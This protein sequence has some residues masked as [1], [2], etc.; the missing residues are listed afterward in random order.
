MRLLFI[1]TAWLMFV[2][3]VLASEPA[4]MGQQLERLTQE[5]VTEGYKFYPISA[6]FNGVSAFNG[7]YAPPWSPEL[8]KA[9]QDYFKRY[10]H[11]LSQLDQAQLSASEQITFDIFQY[12]LELGLERQQYPEELL[13]FNPVTGA[14]LYFATL[15]SGSSGQPFN[16]EQDYRDFM[17]R[18]VG[19]ARW[20]DSM[21]VRLEEAA[22]Q[23]KVLP[24]FTVRAVVKQLEQQLVE[25]V[26]DSPFY[27][28][29]TRL[30]EALSNE[31]SAA[32]RRDYIATI[33]EVILPTYQ[34]LYT[35][36][37]TDYAGKARTSIALEEQD[38]GWYAFYIKQ[39]T[40]LEL[41]PQA[42][43]N[44]G[45]HIVAQNKVA[46]KK[47]K[48][49][50]GFT[51]SLP[52][53][54]QHLRHHDAYYFASAEA[55]IQAY[56]QA[57]ATA[58]Q[59]LDKLFV[60]SHYQDYNVA[61]VPDFAAAQAPKATYRPP[62]PDGSRPATLYINTLDL[63]SQ[64]KY[65]VDSVVLHEAAPGHHLQNLAALQNT[66]LSNYRKSLNFSAYD[67]GWGLYAE[68]LGAQLGLYATP[69]QQLGRVL[70]DQQRAVRVV[71]DTGIHALGWT[72]TQA[73]DYMRENTA[74]S[75]TEIDAEIARYIASPGQALAYKMGE[76]EINALRESARAALGTA[77]S[78]KAFHQTVLATGSVPLPI[79]KQQVRTWVLE[80]LKKQGL[81][82]EVSFTDLAALSHQ[83]FAAI[84]AQ[85]AKVKADVEALF[86]PFE[87][88]ITVAVEFV[89]DNL[90]EVGGVTGVAMTPEQIDISIARQFQA[91][92]DKAIAEGLLAT[93]Y[94]E[95]HHLVRGW[96]VEQNEFLPSIPNAAV[97]EGLAVVFAEQMSGVRESWLDYPDHVAQWLDEILELPLRSDYQQW[98]MGTHPDGRKYVGY[99]VGKY[100]IESALKHSELS[101]N[102]LTFKP[103][104][105][106]IEF[107]QADGRVKDAIDKTVEAYG[108]EALL[109]LKSLTLLD[110]SQQFSRGQ[111]SNVWQGPAVTYLNEVDTTFTIDFE[112]QHKEFK[113]MTR[114]IVGSH[115][116]PQPSI[117]HHLFVDNQGYVVDHAQASYR[118]VQSLRFDTVGASYEAFSDLLIVRNMLTNPVKASWKDIAYIENQAHDVITFQPD[119]GAE[120]TVYLN[121]KTGFIRRLTRMQQDERYT[122]DFLEHTKQNG[123]VYAQ[124]LMVSHATAP[125]YVTQQRTVRY[126]SVTPESIKLP[127][128]VTL[129]PA[130]QFVDASSL[131]FRELAP[132]V[133]FVG[134]DWSYTLFIDDGDGFISAG[135]WQ[136]DAES[137]E[138]QK[139]YEL[140]VQSTGKEL[141][142]KQHIVTHHHH[143]HLHGVPDI[144]AQ[145]ATLIAPAKTVDAIYDYLANAS[146]SAP[147]I[148]PVAD[149]RLIGTRR[150]LL[151][152]VP[153][154]HASHNLAVYLPDAKLLFTEDVFGSSLQQGFHSPS[155]WPENDT[156]VRLE[157]LL[158]KVQAMRFEVEQYVSSHHMRVL[159]PAEIQQALAHMRT[160][161]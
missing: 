94:H 135:A 17:Q 142:V 154:S 8:R 73:Q 117:T 15:G 54:F 7:K 71:V 59:N 106:L 152:D 97:N 108:G 149:H 116:A 43:H 58:Q 70:A 84:V 53:F 80:E 86:A 112:R 146:A 76:Q 34:Q 102:E 118:P 127:K 23:G 20:T 57:S 110:H 55:L 69:I 83:Q 122:Y 28:P 115:H 19:F 120:Y 77:F 18:S 141:P 123:I 157:R 36:F 6:T 111:S 91:G 100:V 62:A 48:A 148:L 96:T 132:G 119:A 38:S 56:Q 52:E 60:G 45:K 90:D 98:M 128:D 144:I 145:G 159:S 9:K 50:L 40:T 136:V 89:D 155:R 85:S 139:A 130:P 30:P 153:T 93:L 125:V 72:Y 137:R 67:E 11:Q 107:A 64:P 121:Q 42:L 68:S 22:Q 37:T 151:L 105:E 95:F 114:P 25:N 35:F 92:L 27:Q 33:N 51:G 13:S 24:Q 156:Y 10:L 81:A 21:I 1:F 26:Q 124:K 131:S 161:L 49:E 134:Q 160:L 66:Q 39:H 101:I 129:A 126:N 82:L 65:L 78:L 99:R 61:Q 140:L 133:Y 104:T 87:Q 88:T 14:H 143:D 113:Q 44:T 41:D 47:L 5:F 63:K 12:Q 3:S 79:L 4:P 74:L 75:T 2:P 16:T 103:V 29:L 46:L 147:T 32:L 31:Q 150:V 109:Q 158:Q 138:W